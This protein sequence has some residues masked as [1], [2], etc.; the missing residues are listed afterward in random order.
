MRRA[1][2][3][4]AYV[5]SEKAEGKTAAATLFRSRL[6]ANSL[7]RIKMR[8]PMLWCLAIKAWNAKDAPVKN[9]IFAKGEA[10]P[11]VAE[12]IVLDKAA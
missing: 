3:F 8:P 2:A 9:L 5:F 7:A 11:E 6:I 12:L 4:W 10:V 1:D